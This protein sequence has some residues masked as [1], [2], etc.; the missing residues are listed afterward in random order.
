MQ[1]QKVLFC[2]IFLCQREDAGSIPT[3][4][5]I[6]ETIKI[7]EITIITIS[8]RKNLFLSLQENVTNH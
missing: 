2:K 6:V 5:G 3:I 4:R 8:I 7:K 1:A